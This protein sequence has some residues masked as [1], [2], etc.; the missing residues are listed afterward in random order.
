MLTIAETKEQRTTGVVTVASTV[1]NQRRE[2][3]ME[4]DQN[5]LVRKRPPDG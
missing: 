5:Y 2:L 4:G 3:V 1:H